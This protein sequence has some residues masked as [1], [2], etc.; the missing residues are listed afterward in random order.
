MHSWHWH[1]SSSRQAYCQF[2]CTD[3]EFDLSQKQRLHNYFNCEEFKTELFLTRLRIDILGREQ[4]IG[5][6]AVQNSIVLEVVVVETG[7]RRV[8]FIRWSVRTVHHWTDIVHICDV[9]CDDS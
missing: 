9:D 6:I 8:G 2:E 7:Q 3:S 1:A 5:D 4:Q